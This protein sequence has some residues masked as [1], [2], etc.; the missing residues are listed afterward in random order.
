MQCGDTNV[1]QQCGV[2]ESFSNEQQTSKP[3][4]WRA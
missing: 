4:I 1:K 2:K 3:I